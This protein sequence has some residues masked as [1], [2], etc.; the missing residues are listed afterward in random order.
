RIHELEQGCATEQVE[1]RRVRVVAGG[2]GGRGGQLIP[3]AQDPLLRQVVR[4][5]E[6]G[7]APLL[8]LQSPVPNDEGHECRTGRARRDQRD[9]PFLGAPQL[10]PDQRGRR[11]E[12]GQEAG[13]GNPAD[14]RLEPVQLPARSVPPGRV[15]LRRRIA[16]GGPFTFGHPAKGNSGCDNG[17]SGETPTG[18]KLTGRNT[19]VYFS[20]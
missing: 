7:G 12:E 8:P 5:P 11:Q 18:R 4:S 19:F 16:P 9:D 2:A 13:V 6:R 15:V 14:P 10:R 1:V 3:P 20:P 17:K